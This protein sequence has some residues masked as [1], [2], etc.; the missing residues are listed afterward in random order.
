[1]GPRPQA[2]GSVLTPGSLASE[3]NYRTPS[4]CPDGWR[5][6][7]GWKT[8]QTVEKHLYT[9]DVSVLVCRRNVIFS[10]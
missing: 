5:I 7:D 9:F 1:M 8:V 2:V 3:D 6:A 4:R 10:F